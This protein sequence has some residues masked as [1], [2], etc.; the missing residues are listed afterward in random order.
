MIGSIDQGD[1][2]EAPQRVNPLLKEC[3]SRANMQNI[4]PAAA[5]ETI[6]LIAGDKE[7]IINIG[8]GLDTMLKEGLTRLLREYA[9]VFARDPK[10][11]PGLQES[12]AL[13]KLNVRPTAKPKIQKRRNFL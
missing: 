12:I 8:A 4:S 6:E 13:H 5:T 10:D 2:E 3:I 9:D 7:R 1:G 11:M